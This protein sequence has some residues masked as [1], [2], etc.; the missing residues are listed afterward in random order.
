MQYLADL[1]VD[2]N[3]IDLSMHDFGCH[4]AGGFSDDARTVYLCRKFSARTLPMD[5]KPA[6]VVVVLGRL[7]DQKHFIAASYRL[8][9]LDT[10]NFVHDALFRHTAEIDDYFTSG[11]APGGPRASPSGRDLLGQAVFSQ[12][13]V[14][15]NVQTPVHVGFAV[16]EQRDTALMAEGIAS[17]YERSLAQGECARV[18]EALSGATAVLR[19][20]S[21]VV[22][23][24]ASI[25]LIG[26]VS[27]GGMVACLRQ[28]Q[29]PLF[30]TRRS[31]HSLDILAGS[32]FKA[33]A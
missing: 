17:E 2:V 16:T 28:T 33:T 14:S 11:P 1:R 30:H 10:V 13:G 18:E 21:A 15:D 31:S 27:G 26:L 6:G 7:I 23:R 25:G 5:I 3:N 29:L 24:A 9:E 22:Y 32:A 12:E 8:D 20:V 19:R 4:W